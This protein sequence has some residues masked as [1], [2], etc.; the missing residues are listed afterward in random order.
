[1]A[2][3]QWRRLL[4][5]MPCASR[6]C[7]RQPGWRWPPWL[8]TTSQPNGPPSAAAGLSVVLTC[9]A[10]MVDDFRTVVCCRGPGAVGLSLFRVSV[11]RGRVMGRPTGLNQSC[12]VSGP[13]AGLPVRHVGREATAP[14]PCQHP[15]RRF[16][17]WS[18]AWLALAATAPYNKSA[19]RTAFGGRWPQR[20]IDLPSQHG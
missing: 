12:M 7:G 15:S 10:N 6:L 17:P 20:C 19:Q 11:V 4:A 13:A 14:F 1:M 2:A 8:H 9:L 18:P 5:S 3:R 16:R